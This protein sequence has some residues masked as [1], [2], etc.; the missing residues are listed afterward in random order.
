MEAGTGRPLP[1][2]PPPPGEESAWQLYKT[3]LNPE[4][5]ILPKDRQQLTRARRPPSIPCNL[6]SIP[7]LSQRTVRCC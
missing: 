1:V 6:T 7:E 5:K 3:A 4:T 2:K